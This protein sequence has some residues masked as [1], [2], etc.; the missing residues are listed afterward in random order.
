MLP[1][2]KQS[3]NILNFPQP[4]DLPPHLARPTSS[5]RGFC[6]AVGG[7]AAPQHPPKH[8]I[9]SSPFKRGEVSVASPVILLHWMCEAAGFGQP[10]YEINISHTGPDG[11]LYFTYKVWIPG[12]NMAFEGVDVILPRPTNVTTIEEAKQAAANQI[13]QKVNHTQYSE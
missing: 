3:S 7:P 2:L 10:Q 6:R 9:T 13:L 8:S 11:Y 1:S 5:P 12:I 4:S